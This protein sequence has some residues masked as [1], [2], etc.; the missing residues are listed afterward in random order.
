MTPWADEALVVAL[1]AIQSKAKHIDTDV[2]EAAKAEAMMTA[3]HGMWLELE[4]EPV[5]AGDSVEVFFRV[6]LRDPDGREVPGWSLTGKQ[7]ALKQLGHLTKPTPV[8]HKTTGS[9]ITP[10][11]DYW[12]RIAVDGQ[13]SGYIDAARALGHDCDAAFYDVSKKPDISPERETPAEK[14]K[15]TKGKGCTA[16]G[17]SAG[18]K[19]GIVQGTGCDPNVDDGANT[20]CEPCKGTGWKEAP[21]FAANVNLKD[22]DPLDYKAR[23]IEKIAEN[24]GVY[25]Q[26]AP[27]TRTDEQIAEARADLVCATVEIDAYYNRM[28][29]L[30]SKPDDV[31]A[32]YAFPRNTSTCL[33]I[34]GRRCDFLDVCS[35]SV[36]DPA[37]SQLYRIRDRKAATGVKS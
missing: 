4:F 3:Y 15:M 23:V 22:E 30:A 34:Y 36:S 20:V 32:R 28:R 26:Q 13:I 24:P 18:G 16:C 37:Q 17:G 33:N 14:R 8:E 6:P 5:Q 31:Q 2:Y 29:K 9:D 10:G 1:K 19:R 25:F 21:R 11:S 27:V 35:G 12:Q 7:D